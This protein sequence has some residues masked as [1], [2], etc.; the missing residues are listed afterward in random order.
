MENLKSLVESLSIKTS[1]SPWCEFKCNNFEPNMIGEDISALANSAAYHDR[2]KAYMIWGIDDKTYEIVGTQYNQFS[3]FKGNQELESWLRNLRSSNCEFEFHNVEMNNKKVVV[4]IIH[5]A[6][7]QTVTFKK[8]D[9]IR[10]GSY[11]KNLMDNPSMQATLWDKIRSTKF[12]NIYAIQNLTVSDALNKLDYSV[13]FDLK[14]IPIPTNQE[15]II[16]Y[17]LEESIIEKQDNGQYAIT[18]LGAILFAKRLKEFKNLTRK[19]IRIIQYDDNSR[20]KILKEYTESQGYVIGFERAITFLEAVLPS[21]EEIQ[22]A[23]RKTKRI[24]PMVALREIIANALIH[25]DFSITGAGITIEVFDNRIE[26]TNPG[27]PLIDVQRIVDN[28]PKSRNEKLAS[29]MRNLKMCEELGSGWDRIVISCEIDLL[30]APKLNVYAESTKVTIYSQQ[31]F[32]NITSEDKLWS[33]YLHA[34]V[35]QVNGETI[36]NTSLRERFGLDT[37]SSASI[38]RLIKE[39]VL[40]ELIKPLDKTTA[41]KHMKY[42]PIWA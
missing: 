28:P 31:N 24:Y 12:E 1:E 4:L 19:A 18:N 25:Q 13:Y 20:L 35:R 15:N 29:L 42:I 7:Y 11:T 17:M 14:N 27:I 34:C 9:Y 40:K 37:K 3:K 38:S 22:G 36:T 33:C 5:K 26:V 41:P 8:V 23:T 2:D 6:T 39:A 32:S 21:S 30:P 10:V 16:H